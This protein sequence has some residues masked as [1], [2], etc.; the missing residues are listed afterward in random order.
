MILFLLL[1]QGTRVGYID[2]KAVMDN[3]KELQEAREELERYKSEWE[4]K[5][6][7]V[8]R[9][10]DSLQRVYRERRA[11]LTD[12]ERLAMEEEIESTRAEYERVLKDMVRAVQEKSKE[13][14]TPYT[15]KITEAVKKIAKGLGLQLVIDISKG[16]VVYTD[17]KLDIT[18]L[19]LGEL[20]KE[21][22]EAAVIQKRKL[23]VFP[24]KE[25]NQDARNTRLG[26][27]IQESMAAVF[28]RSP[29]FDVTDIQLVNQTMEQQDMTT[30]NMNEDQVRDLVVSLGG[31]LYV[32][33]TV[34]RI[35]D[36]AEFEVG[37]YLS[38]GTLIQ[39][40]RKRTRVQ[41]VSLSTE[42]QNTASSLLNYY[43]SWLEKHK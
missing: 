16:G 29:R 7:S 21:Y 38:D 13:I 27:K 37:L 14:L 40:V 39:K 43:I 18:G 28:K 15:E 19:V 36:D 25:L 1:Q 34:R 20:N 8:K 22:A 23:I 31:E 30:E 35:G 9:R 6:D 5:A 2:L 17:P 32:Y 12:A 3:Y 33:G 24:L 10:L 41:E 42:A 11:M 26:Y 4:L